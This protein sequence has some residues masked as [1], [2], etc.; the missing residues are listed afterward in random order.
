MFCLTS[1]DEGESILNCVVEIYCSCYGYSFII[2]I[3]ILKHLFIAGA[4]LARAVR[5]EG[6]GAQKAEGRAG[7]EDANGSWK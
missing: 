4:N 3:Y 6:F 5:R 2:E 7:A 1:D